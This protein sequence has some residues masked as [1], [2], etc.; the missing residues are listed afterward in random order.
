MHSQ[1]IP[2]V[3]ILDSLPQRMYKIKI[4]SSIF[5]AST[6]GLYSIHGAYL[7]TSNRFYCSPA[8]SCLIQIYSSSTSIKCGLRGNWRT[9]E[10]P[11]ILTL[12]I[13]N[14]FT[15]STSWMWE[16]SNNKFWWPNW[17]VC[18]SYTYI[19]IHFYCDIPYQFFKSS[20][21]NS[22][23]FFVF[24][25]FLKTPATISYICTASFCNF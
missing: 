11:A 14:E 9:W 25:L 4:I 24:I 20:K 17:S 16:H 22:Q 3:E 23:F 21:I 5:S 12:W 1:S 7:G 2:F 19:K 8:H 15:R 18:I 13:C 6:Q 10:Q